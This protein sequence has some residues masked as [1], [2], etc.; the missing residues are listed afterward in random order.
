[1]TIGFS[2]LDPTTWSAGS[3]TIPRW[4]RALGIPHAASHGPPSEVEWHTKTRAEIHQGFQ[5]D[6]DGWQ[7][8]ECAMRWMHYPG[9][10]SWVGKEMII[11]CLLWRAALQLADHQLA[12]WSTFAQNLCASWLLLVLYNSA[13]SNAITSSFL[14]FFVKRQKVNKVWG[15]CSRVC[16]VKLHLFYLIL[17]K[18]CDVMLQ[19]D[20]QKQS[21]PIMFWKK[22]LH[23][24]KKT[25][26]S[27]R[28]VVLQSP[29]HQPFSPLH[30]TCS[31]GQEVSPS[32]G[33]ATC[34][35]CEARD[36]EW[37]PMGKS[38]LER[39][40]A[41]TAVSVFWLK[42]VSLE[43]KFLQILKLLQLPYVF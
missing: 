27:G 23:F 13:K 7:C 2:S 34:E 29:A 39:L 26:E 35:N 5:H 9:M 31:H 15:G 20:T 38:N 32:S 3:R 10:C 42:H 30:L 16:G 22:Q 25:T 1:M 41:Q 37:P 17:S 40:Q 21:Q 4:S 28:G 11:S 19:W 43:S 12:S 33:W 14:M 18:S 8:H 24:V 6:T 36:C